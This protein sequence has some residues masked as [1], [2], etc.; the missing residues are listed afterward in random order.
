MNCTIASPR[1]H[2]HGRYGLR[3]CPSPAPAVTADAHDL[4]TGRRFS[5]H[6][7]MNRK[8][9]LRPV[10][11]GEYRLIGP[12][13]DLSHMLEGDEEHR[14][15]FERGRQGE[16]NASVDHHIVR[17]HEETYH[18]WGCVR[19]TAVGRV[20]YHWQSDDLERAP[21]TSTGEAVRA[22]QNAGESIGE[23]NG[24][25]FIQSPYFVELEGRYFM[26]Y[27]G[28]RSGMDADGRPVPAPAIPGE[29][30]QAVGQIC[31]MTSDD[32]V[33]WERHRNPDRTSRLFLGPGMSRDPCVVCI[34]GL[35]HMY[36]AG[37]VDPKQPEAGAGFVVRTS[38]NLLDWSDWRLIH[39]DP[40]Y[41]AHHTDTECPFVIEK[42]GY[43][44]LFRTVDYYYCRTLVFRSEDPY[45]FGIGDASSKL[46]GRL[47]AAAPELYAFGERE[48]VSSSHAPLFGE[49]LAPL[50]WIE[51][52]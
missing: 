49:S 30:D 27:G 7:S 17:D 15:A 42:E 10:L 4:A 25:E 51:D 14:V 47:P 37:Y 36:Y 23:P 29:P 39:R 43:F 19:S 44:Y 45:D 41:G 1:L 3:R 20:L 52:E 33:R 18:L 6:A 34:D 8:R 28:H 35:W 46:V 16:H 40:R 32:G 48:Y 38:Q 13:P 12:N 50:A 26:F 5:Y 11:D 2:P 24:E 9:R 31:L 21:W 22:D